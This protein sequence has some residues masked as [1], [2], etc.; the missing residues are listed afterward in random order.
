M[1]DRFDKR[2]ET[3][4][5]PNPP[6]PGLSEQS[7][8]MCEGCRSRRLSERDV[9]MVQERDALSS[10]RGAAS[11]ANTLRIEEDA[12]KCNTNGTMRREAALKVASVAVA[13][14][15]NFISGMI[16][17]YPY[18]TAWLRKD[19]GVTEGQITIIGNLSQASLG[20]FVL[21]LA[22]F[23]A[24]QS[25]RKDHRPADFRY[26]LI[27][28]LIQSLGMGLVCL[29]T[30]KAVRGSVQGNALAAAL[31]AGFLLNGG[32]TASIFS[33]SCWVIAATYAGH[34]I[35]KR[36]LIA[37]ISF[38]MG[39]GALFFSGIL[40]NLVKLRPWDLIV[41]HSSLALVSGV[42]RCA[43]L[44]KFY[45]PEALAER[46]E[47][48]KASM[49]TPLR[50]EFVSTLT[51]F[52]TSALA[53]TVFV[54]NMVVIGLGSTVNTITGNVLMTTGQDD[55]STLGLCV[56]MGVQSFGRALVSILG[57]VHDCSHWIFVASNTLL[58]AA[59]AIPWTLG[60][61]FEYF[62]AT[63]ALSGFAFGVAWA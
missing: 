38:M 6:P 46:R 52:W 19:L 8:R 22:I 25:R 47:A 43:F 57:G 24:Q 1:R 35:A 60:S 3:L 13:M 32:A 49:K 56:F 40:A 61:S 4:A 21:P 20:L 26:S 11:A 48:L 16:Y 23:H 29:F 34:P 7:A 30:S 45:A 53:I 12:E 58:V 41:L 17:L 42:L 62:G 51:G 36:V 14:F 37:A 50:R 28:G 59:F 44:Y 5:R 15:S 55:K 18:Y 2:F 54:S 9:E 63:S 33:H 39:L 10:R 27:T 31:G